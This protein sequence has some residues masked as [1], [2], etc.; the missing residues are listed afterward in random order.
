MLRHAVEVFKSLE[1]ENKSAKGKAVIKLAAKLLNA[2]L[3]MIK[4]DLSVTIP[5]EAKNWEKR[6][7]QYDQLIEQERKLTNEGIDGILIEF[8]AQVLIDS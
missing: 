7:V 3:K 2:R 4:A 8:D 6:R 5:V 1:D